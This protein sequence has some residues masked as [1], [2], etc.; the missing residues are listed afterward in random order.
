MKFASQTYALWIVIKAMHTGLY[1]GSNVVLT[2]TLAW[3]L[4]RKCLRLKLSLR[5]LAQ[6]NVLIFVFPCKAPPI[7]KKHPRN[8]V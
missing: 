3:S 8:T 6:L 7:S 2:E 4:I 5:T 1:K